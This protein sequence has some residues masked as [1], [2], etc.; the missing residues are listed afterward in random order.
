MVGD[1]LAANGK[2]LADLGAF[3]PGVVM[4]CFA[5]LVWSVI[6]N[7]SLWLFRAH[8]PRSRSVKEFVLRAFFVYDARIDKRLVARNHLIKNICG[9]ATLLTMVATRGY[10]VT[11]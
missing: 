11:G 9:F 7:L 2:G 3:P 5:I 10:F 6:A 8:L 1:A 4:M